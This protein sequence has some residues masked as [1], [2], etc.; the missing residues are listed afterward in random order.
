MLVDGPQPVEMLKK[1]RNDWGPLGPLHHHMSIA[2]SGSGPWLSIFVISGNWLLPNQTSSSLPFRVS[3]TGYKG[4]SIDPQ[5]HFSGG[6]LAGVPKLRSNIN[7][8]SKFLGQVFCIREMGLVV[9][10]RF[11]FFGVTTTGMQNPLCPSGTQ[12]LLS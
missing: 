6:Y 11:N 3:K 5:I 8:K 12:P 4:G 9:N 2:C 10:F 1:L 7:S